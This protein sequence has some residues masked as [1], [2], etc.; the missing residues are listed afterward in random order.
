MLSAYENK[1]LIVVS[2]FDLVAYFN[3]TPRLSDVLLDA[4]LITCAIKR[5][6]HV[7]KVC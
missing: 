1:D 7:F 2:M 4:Y 3:C 5:L 6:H